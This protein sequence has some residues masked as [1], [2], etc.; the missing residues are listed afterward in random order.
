MRR[1]VYYAKKDTSPITFCSQLAMMRSSSVTI[2]VT[3]QQMLQPSQQPSA[4]SSVSR[5]QQTK[6]LRS[7]E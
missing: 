5:G 6:E 1:G 3:D 7:R 4:I 2:G